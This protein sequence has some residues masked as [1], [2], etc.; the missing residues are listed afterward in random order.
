MTQR[1]SDGWLWP[2][3]P[4]VD[5]LHSV[6]RTVHSLQQTESLQWLPPLYHHW[7]L[8]FTFD[9]SDLLSHDPHLSMELTGCGWWDW[10]DG[11]GFAM[12]VN[13]GKQ[14]SYSG[15][16]VCVYKYFIYLFIYLHIHIYI[17][18]IYIYKVLQ[19]ALKLQRE[20]TSPSSF[21]RI[22]NGCIW[23]SSG[24]EDDTICTFFWSMICCS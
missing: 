3:L 1:L 24:R 22:L 21:A 6:V 10:A 2:H 17:F 18:Y 4:Q 15:G 23:K 8:A 13:G 19:V 11:D 20:K 12:F 14:D 5:A 7:G 9:T 16:G